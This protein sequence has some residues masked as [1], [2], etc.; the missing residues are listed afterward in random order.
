M[1][2]S[3]Q[4][5]WK[6]G[7]QYGW[8]GLDR[9]RSYGCCLVLA[10]N[11]ISRKMSQHCYVWCWRSLLG[12]DCLLWPHRRTIGRWLPFSLEDFWKGVENVPL[13]VGMTLSRTSVKDARDRDP[14]IK[15]RS[16]SGFKIV[17]SVMMR[18][19]LQLEDMVWLL[20][21]WLILI[22]FQQK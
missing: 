12:E 16:S 8:L 13:P 20:R 15:S 9:N 18:S 1:Q 17:H 22:I 7:T 3:V 6:N 14:Q 10:H 2:F 11:S 19:F 4:F 5:P 21:K